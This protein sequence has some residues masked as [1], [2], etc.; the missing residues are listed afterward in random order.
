VTAREREGGEKP[1]RDGEGSLG[2]KRRSLEELFGEETRDSGG[3]NSGSERIVGE[4]EREDSGVIRSQKGGAGEVV[5]R[6]VRESAPGPST[7]MG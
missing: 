6:C 1:K 7:P 3:S 4:G 2:A 5:E